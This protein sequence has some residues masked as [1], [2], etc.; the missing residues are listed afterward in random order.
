MCKLGLYIH[1]AVDLFDLNFQ[2]S[3]E[4]KEHSNA[5]QLSCS[6]YPRKLLFVS[7]CPITHSQSYPTASLDLHNSME[8]VVYFK[9]GV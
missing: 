4:F 5:F 6:S 7:P 3:V 8:N 9:T 2:Y 1:H